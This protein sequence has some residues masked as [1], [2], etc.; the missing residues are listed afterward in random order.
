[1]IVALD[2]GDLPRTDPVWATNAKTGT[3]TMIVA[4]G[5]KAKYVGVVG[6]YRTN[7]PGSRSTSAISSW[8]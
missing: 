5:E 3:K 1:M 8:K 7:K 6:V 2:D 4:L